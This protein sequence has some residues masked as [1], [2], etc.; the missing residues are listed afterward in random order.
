MKGIIYLERCG[1]EIPGSA[2]CQPAIVGSLPTILN[3]SH[4][5]AFPISGIVLG[6]LPSTTGWQPVLPSKT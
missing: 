3:V 6:K 5:L 1:S 4:A 2:G